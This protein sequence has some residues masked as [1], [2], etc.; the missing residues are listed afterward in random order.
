ML[1][2]PSDLHLNLSKSLGVHQS[3]SKILYLHETMDRMCRYNTQTDW[4]WKNLSFDSCCPNFQNKP[5]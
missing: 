2:S 5:Q 4:K 3:S 1:F